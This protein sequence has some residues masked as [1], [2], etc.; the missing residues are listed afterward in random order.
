MDMR[1]HIKER[2]ELAHTYAC[3]GAYVRAAEILEE[4][5]ATIRRHANGLERQSR[6]RHDRIKAQA[7]AVRPL[8]SV[9]HRMMKPGEAKRWIRDQIDGDV[10]IDETPYNKNETALIV[11]RVDWPAKGFSVKSKDGVFDALLITP[12]LSDC[13]PLR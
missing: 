13:A 5:A 10:T 8:L 9:T 3:D 4:L 2:S 12:F 6:N 7:D 1:N 11:R